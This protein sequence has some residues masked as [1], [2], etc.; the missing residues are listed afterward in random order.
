M[1]TNNLNLSFDFKSEL[2]LHT[3]L[4]NYMSNKF[5]I[6]KIINTGI[7]KTKELIRQT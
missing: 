3:E 2:T 6:I 4:D 1:P 5:T 7:E